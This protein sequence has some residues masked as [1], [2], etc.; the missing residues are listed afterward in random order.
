MSRL[1]RS[2]SGVIR[3]VPLSL[4]CLHGFLP[5]A[6]SFAMPVHSDAAGLRFAGLGAGVSMSEPSAVFNVCALRY[7]SYYANQT[8]SHVCA[9]RAS[10]IVGCQ[11][12]RA[13]STEAAAAAPRGRQAACALQEE[14]LCIAPCQRRRP[15]REG[16][17]QGDYHAWAH[18]RRPLP[19]DERRQLAAGSEGAGGAPRRHP[20]AP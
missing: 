3:F 10:D 4:A 5:P 7:R 16:G 18:A 2:S 13:A 8:S 17:E 11:T 20:G 14:F 6:R 12:G 9:L 15:S 1:S 19:M